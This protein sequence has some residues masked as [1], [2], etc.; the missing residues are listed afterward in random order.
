MPGE[1]RSQKVAEWRQIQNGDGKGRGINIGEKDQTDSKGIPICI[2]NSSCWKK[3]VGGTSR[4]A[5]ALC[6]F[7]RG[8]SPTCLGYHKPAVGSKA[9]GQKAISGQAIRV[10]GS[11]KDK[12]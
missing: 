8:E 12:E 11:I 3:S 7:I 5:A 1:G 10:R 4:G 9:I 6:D 2:S